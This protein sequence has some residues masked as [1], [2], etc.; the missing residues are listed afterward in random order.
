MAFIVVVEQ[1][2]E[3]QACSLAHCF[4]GTNIMVKNTDHSVAET[5]HHRLLAL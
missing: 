1:A 5:W 2:A 3:P 4:L